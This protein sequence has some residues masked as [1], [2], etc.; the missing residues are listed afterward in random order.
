MAEGVVEVVVLLLL[1]LEA[2][3]DLVGCAI[4][5]LMPPAA[6]RMRL[7]R[8]LGGMV[9][10]CIAGDNSR[11]RLLPGPGRGTW[12]WRRTKSSAGGGGQ[13]GGGGQDLR[14]SRAK[15]GG[16]AADQG[17]RSGSERGKERQGLSG[18]SASRDSFLSS[19]L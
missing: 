7:F 1:A 4:A 12:V 3:F 13:G 19:S 10:I 16:E 14:T 11:V 2:T 18:Q 9:D 15:A 6:V 5:M 8:E 17:S